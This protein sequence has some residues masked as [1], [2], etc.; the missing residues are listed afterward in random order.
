[1]NSSN[2]AILIILAAV[3]VLVFYFILL[4][5]QVYLVTIMKATSILDGV[6]EIY[7]V[8]ATENNL[9]YAGPFVRLSV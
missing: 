2:I 5:L 1:M 7:R 6:N 8:L 3:F 9:V 4:H